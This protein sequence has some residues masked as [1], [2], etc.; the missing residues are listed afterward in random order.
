MKTIALLLIGLGTI[1]ISCAPNED[2]KATTRSTDPS[3]DVEDNNF[4]PGPG[5]TPPKA[6]PSKI[7]VGSEFVWK[8]NDGKSGCFKWT[9]TEN[10]NDTMAAIESTSTK[11]EKYRDFPHRELAWDTENGE[12]LYDILR[13]N[14]ELAEKND[15]FTNI[16]PMMVMGVRKAKY[17]VSV[18]KVNETSY[19]VYAL[20]SNP[21]IIYA[22]TEDAMVGV[23]LKNSA[24]GNL[25]PFT[26]L[27]FVPAK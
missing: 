24:K 6:L 26:F 25:T 7:K 13:M 1:V 23:V 8:Y 16:L 9:I 18:I 3:K 11:C 21:Q 14:A 5:D 17:K 4:K 12:V 10:K 2:G 20:D 19:P 27:N 22:H 15:D